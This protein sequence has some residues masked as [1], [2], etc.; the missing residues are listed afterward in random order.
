M[1]HRLKDQMVVEMRG[2]W[3]LMM[4]WFQLVI[5][6]HPDASIAAGVVPHV[7]DVMSHAFRHDHQNYYYGLIHYSKL[8]LLLPLVIYRL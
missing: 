8:L 3:V 6:G 5:D 1:I 2:W 7:D 4:L